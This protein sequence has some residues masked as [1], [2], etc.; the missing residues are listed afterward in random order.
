MPKI[1]VTIITFN[2][3]RRIEGALRSVAWADERI[4]VDSGSTDDTVALARALADRV[5][6]RDWPGYGTQKNAA[7]SLASHDWILS[8]DADERVTP[9]LAETIRE[10]LSTEPRERAFRIARVTWHL[11]RWI[12]STDWYPDRQTRL[13]D[14]RAA[15]WNARRVHEGLD[16]DG[17]VGALAGE[18]E[19]F[20]YR[21]I[22]H[23]LQTIDR[24]STLAA[25]QMA[26]DGRR[27]SVFDL[28]VHPPAAF[29]RNYLWRGGVREGVAGLVVSSMNAFYV[30][31]KFA[32]LWERQR[33]GPFTG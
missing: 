6:V 21:D 15:A 33:A 13:Y 1:S 20:A 4:V 32:K 9:A 5:E 12:R 18:I 11:G 26:A 28:V 8:I 16:V 3:A 29:A 27:A 7:A 30:F 17:E 25:E 14:R 22:A 19:H 10:A 2:E 23:H 31:L 24:Y